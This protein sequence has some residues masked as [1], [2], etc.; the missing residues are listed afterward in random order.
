LETAVRRAFQGIGQAEISYLLL[1]VMHFNQ[2]F[3][4]FY[5]LGCPAF[6]TVIKTEPLSAS[7]KS[8]KTGQK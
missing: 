2:D 6:L 7:I 3:T 1:G 8:V 5:F 4:V